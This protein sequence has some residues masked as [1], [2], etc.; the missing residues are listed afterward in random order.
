MFKM[1]I[2]TAI[3]LPNNPYESKPN[4]FGDLYATHL[5]VTRDPLIMD[6]WRGGSAAAHSTLGKGE[7]DD[8]N[9][10]NNSIQRLPNTSV[11]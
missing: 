1:L 2:L 8:D 9:S 6:F 4:P 5:R 3:H 10:T 11:C 7:K